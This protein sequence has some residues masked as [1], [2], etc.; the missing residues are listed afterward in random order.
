MNRRT[1]PVRRVDAPESRLYESR[2]AL[3][4]VDTT[5]NLSY[6]EGRAVPY[7]TVTDTGWFYFEQWASGALSDSIQAAGG[8]LP[9]L[10]WHDSRTWPIGVGEEWIEAADGLH[11]VWRLD[12]SA[13]AQ[14]AAR[15]AR[16]GFLT[17]MSISFSPIESHW[18][19][20]ADWEDWDPNDPDTWD[21]VTRLRAR[22]LETS[23]TPTPA[24]A[25]AQVALVRSVEGRHG[26]ARQL[27]GG[28]RR[29]GAP[30]RSTAP[31][32]A[33]G[34]SDTPKLTRWKAWRASL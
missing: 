21:V 29:S 5:T 4:D 33:G 20:N 30:A 28:Q 14:R 15:Q 22:L 8:R 19:A 6:L 27:G 3:A 32:P 1:G 18:E 23:L 31:T 26:R 25:D 16:D 34:A 9:L 2:V 17:G 13:E 10:T 11:G 12:D 7:D 24:Y